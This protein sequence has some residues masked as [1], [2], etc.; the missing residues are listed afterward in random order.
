M[1]GATRK[2]VVYLDS[3]PEVDV[4]ATYGLRQ[5]PDGRTI[6]VPLPVTKDL[7]TSLLDDNWLTSCGG[8]FRRGRVTAEYFARVP[9]YM[10]YTHLAFQIARDRTVHVLDDP[11]PHY[12]QIYTSGSDSQGL[13][14]AMAQPYAL[15]QMQDGSLPQEFR[16]LL[17]RK[18]AAAFHNAA[19][20]CYRS[21]RL[22]DAWRFHIASLRNRHG[23]KYLPLSG[24]LLVATLIRVGK[25][26]HLNPADQQ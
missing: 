24:H 16:I 18:V 5:A 8:A 21:G 13:N 17:A 2:R 1:P 15:A 6:R 19:N 7:L 23:L 25:C 3:H 9:R 4:L 26:R 14:F 10:E 11:S 12:T 20:Y 22:L